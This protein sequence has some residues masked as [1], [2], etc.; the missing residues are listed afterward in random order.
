MASREDSDESYV[1]GLCDRILGESALTQ[2]R[3]DWLLGDPGAGGR[4]VR[5]PVDA[6]WPGRRLVVEYRELQ[7]DRPMPHFDKPDRL[8]VSGVHRGEQRALYD[9]RRE[10]LI[11]AHGLRLVIVRPADLVADGRGRLRRDEAA[12]LAALE[13]I[14]APG[15]DGERDGTAHV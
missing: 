2:H 6:Y 8:T 7:H 10:E 14:L 4:R 12:D 5:L 1:V 3:F 15:R 9:A 13:A 11:P